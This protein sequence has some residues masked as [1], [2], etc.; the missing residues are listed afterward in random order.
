MNI[1]FCDAC[2]TLHAGTMLDLIYEMQLNCDQTRYLPDVT[3]RT[4]WLARRSGVL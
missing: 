3:P 1:S 4:D 2:V